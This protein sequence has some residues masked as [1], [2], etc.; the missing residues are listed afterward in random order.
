MICFSSRGRVLWRGLD[1]RGPAVVLLGRSGQLRRRREPRAPGA[2]LGRRKGMRTKTLENHAQGVFSLLFVRS[3]LWLDRAERGLALRR[4]RRL[5]A[6]GCFH[7]DGGC[8][9]LSFGGGRISGPALT[10]SHGAGS[11]LR[12]TFWQ[13]YAA[14]CR[15]KT[16]G[17][18]MRI[19]KTET[20]VFSR[21]SE[22]VTSIRRPSRIVRSWG[23][24][25]WRFLYAH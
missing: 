12:C 2:R 18:C 9:D 7:R 5:C 3:S 24:L 1:A 16:W 15:P 13:D 19:R 21:R 14:R 8:G 20:A 17:A 23:Y 25:N 10:S 22:D 11:F 6:S 4:C